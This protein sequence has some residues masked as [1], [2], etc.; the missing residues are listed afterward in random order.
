MSVRTEIIL[1]ILAMLGIIAFAVFAEP[2]GSTSKRWKV[3]I[4][5]CAW[6][7]ATN[8]IEVHHVYPQH[9][10]PERA[11]DTNN[12]I[13]LCPRCHLVIGHRCNWTNCVT[14]LLNMIREG[15]K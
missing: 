8:E 5:P 7:E 13:C 1:G 11:H 4:T 10:W 12:M 9:L 6:C 15:K 3:I 2:V 14:N